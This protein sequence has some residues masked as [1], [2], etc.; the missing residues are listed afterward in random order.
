M[1]RSKLKRKSPRRAR[2]PA[3]SRE[4]IRP[5]GSSELRDQRVGRDALSHQDAR[6]RD[7]EAGQHA[8]P[9]GDELRGDGDGDDEVLAETVERGSSGGEAAEVREGDE[10]RDRA[11]K[12]VEEQ[13]GDGAEDAGTG[14]A[15]GGELGEGR[16]LHLE[17]SH[18]EQR[19]GGGALANGGDLLGSE[20][21]PRQGGGAN[22][23][24]RD[25]VLKRHGVAHE[26]VLGAVRG[27]GEQGTREQS[28]RRRRKERRKVT[29]STASDDRAETDQELRVHPKRIQ[30]KERRRR[31][32]RSRRSSNAQ[33]LHHRAHTRAAEVFRLNLSPRRD[34]R[35]TK[36]PDSFEHSLHPAHARQARQ[37]PARVAQDVQIH[38]HRHRIRHG[39][40]RKHGLGRRS[41]RSSRARSLLRGRAFRR[42]FP[43]HGWVPLVRRSECNV[44]NERHETDRRVV[45][46]VALFARFVL[47]ARV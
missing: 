41:R 19:N 33:R 25:G 46:L 7:V 17:E 6:A 36:H 23:Q 37:R 5:N 28:H 12:R 20:L 29:S 21:L 22:V 47:R 8:I 13:T 34:R 38:H 32:Q 2:W 10:E 35:R 27:A 39:H 30:Q 26:G 11:V 45:A 3:R 24:Q 42:F 1:E 31:R 18:H 16:A 40:G 44:M 43:R 14:H 9:R 15:G 4:I